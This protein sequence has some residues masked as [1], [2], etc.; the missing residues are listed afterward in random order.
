[1]TNLFIAGP[2]Q[3]KTLHAIQVAHDT[4]AYLITTTMAE[5]KRVNALAQ[6]LGTP[7]R[8]PL[9]FD[10]FQQ[11][12]LRGS[13]VRNIVVDNLDQMLP[14]FFPGLTLEAVT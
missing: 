5:A 2:S 12:Q 6:N 14:G 9:F 4:K 13:R 8:F 7:I 3:G 1:M 11:H 10:E